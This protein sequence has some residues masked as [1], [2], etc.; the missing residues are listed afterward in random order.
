M[1][2]KSEREARE[3]E[4]EIEQMNEEMER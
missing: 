2:E 3:K 4:R 1:K